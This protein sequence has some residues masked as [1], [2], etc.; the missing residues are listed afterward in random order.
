M[1]VTFDF[2]S[3]LALGIIVFVTEISKDL[4][5]LVRDKLSEQK[6]AIRKQHDHHE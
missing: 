3:Y 5:K 2:W 1:S 6:N 4:Y